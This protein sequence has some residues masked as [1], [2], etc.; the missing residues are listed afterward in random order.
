[1]DALVVTYVLYL[2]ISIGLTV[3]V[4]HTLSRNGKVFLVDVFGGDQE[5][6]RTVNHLLVVGFYLVNF[7]FVAWYLR[8][9]DA[10]GETRQVFETLSVKVGTVLIVLGV[11][12][13]GNVFV[14]SRMRRRSLHQAR[15]LPPVGP[16]AYTSVA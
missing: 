1:M 12:H 6:A 8:T 13:L 2:L 16:D 15:D 4:G 7:G 14:L 11:L 9:A 10:V 5:L 3:W